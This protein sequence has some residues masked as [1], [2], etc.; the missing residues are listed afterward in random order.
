ML[1]H[2]DFFILVL[3]SAFIFLCIQMHLHPAAE[4][5]NVRVEL[6]TVMH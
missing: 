2:A 4:T 1:L 3:F 6:H 5:V